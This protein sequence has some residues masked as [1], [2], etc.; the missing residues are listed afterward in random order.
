MCKILLII[1]G[2]V[3]LP[4][5]TF[6]AGGDAIRG[7]AP[8]TALIVDFQAG[9]H[10]VL[11]NAYIQEELDFFLDLGG[12]PRGALR[13]IH[14]LRA[15]GRAIA[16]GDY[17]GARGALQ[18]VKG[19]RQNVAYL[20]AVIDSAQGNHRRGLEGFRALIDDREELSP[21]LRNL[22]FIGAARVFHEIKDYAQA[23]YHYNQVRQLAPEFYQAVFE[24]AWSFY[25][26]GDM[27]G[28]L[29]VTL[30]FLSPYFKSAFYP[31]ALLVRAASFYQ[32]CLFERANASVETLKKIY[33]PLQLQLK[34]LV[35]RNPESWLFEERILKSVHPKVV[36][37]LIAD[38]R[39]RKAQRA[40]LGLREENSRLRDDRYRALNQHGLAR[41][42]KQ[43]VLETKRVLRKAFKEVNAV[44]AKADLIQ[45]EVLQ[46][47]ANVLLRGKAGGQKKKVPIIDL[48]SVDFDELVQFWPFHGEYWVDELGS[49]Y[50]GLKSQCDV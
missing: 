1:I 9:N 16:R 45:I 32:L 43:L 2:F 48:G 14:I 49:Y 26:N 7:V 25:L 5:L 27:N 11:A 37:R 17:A 6:S 38:N 12:K 18:M 35:G 50:Y 4:A 13:E 23:I 28:S 41:V 29:G 42:Q 46:A 8:M 47:G 44:M 33:K 31:E 24:K 36:G 39:F 30:S 21:K 34:D 15:A 20:K 22:A 19:F 3:F 40:Y 10:D